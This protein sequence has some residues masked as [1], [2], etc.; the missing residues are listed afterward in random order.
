VRKR[1]LLREQHI[2]Q[3]HDVFS[4]IGEPKRRVLIEQL[5]IK[6]MTVNELVEIVEWP[7]P[8]VSKHL[9][10]LRKV[11]IVSERKEGRFR[12]YRIEPDE[13][14]PI[15]EWLHQFEKFWGGT[16]DQLDEYLRKIQNNG[17]DNRK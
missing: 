14:R 5:V 15:Q 17:I 13:L 8:T 6:E 9:C 3:W 1:L 7:Q 4:A 16:M 12:Y 11:N 10:V 2:Q